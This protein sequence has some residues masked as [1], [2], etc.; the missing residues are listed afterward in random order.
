MQW[1]NFFGHFQNNIIQI[2]YSL[3]HVFLKKISFSNRDQFSSSNYCNCAS[4]ACIYSLKNIWTILEY[5]LLFYCGV[6]SQ[7]Q[8]E[9]P[10]AECLKPKKSLLTIAL[11]LRLL[12]TQKKLF[13]CEVRV[14]HPPFVLG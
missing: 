12:S 3:P 10:G 13:G 14:H 11:A 9:R 1:S 5:Q 2:C 4:N 6:F 7:R 8:P